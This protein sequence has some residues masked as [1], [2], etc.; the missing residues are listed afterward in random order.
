MNRFYGTVVDLTRDAELAFL[1]V[2]SLD[3]IFQIMCPAVRPDGG[4]W[5]QGD[6]V[7]LSVS[8]IHVGLSV[9]LRGR[10][11]L[12]NR[13]PAW[14]TEIQKGRIQSLVRCATGHYLME[15]LITTEALDE[16]GIEPGAKVELLVKSS[17]ISVCRV[18]PERDT[19]NCGI[20]GSRGL[21]YVT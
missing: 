9:L 13:I 15:S 10:L 2:S 5:E 21:S 4:L 8:P 1:T 11:S 7:S 16:L 12:R 18:S 20:H 19:G 14:V 17:D 3:G 6:D